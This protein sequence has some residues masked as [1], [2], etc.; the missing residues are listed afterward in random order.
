MENY[1]C[2]SRKSQ[3]LKFIAY[4]HFSWFSSSPSETIT[5]FP[6]DNSFVCSVPC[7][8]GECLSAIRDLSMVPNENFWKLCTE[9]TSENS[10][11]FFQEITLN[12]LLGL[13]N[14]AT[15]AL[16]SLADHCADIIIDTVDHIRWRKC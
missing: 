9:V 3:T 2:L 7:Y 6:M 12:L 5:I 13:W 4:L 14:Q 1:K 8:L 10:G 15:S 11:I 16:H